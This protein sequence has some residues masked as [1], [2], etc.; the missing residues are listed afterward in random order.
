MD[1]LISPKADALLNA[2]I[3]YVLQQLQPANLQTTLIT[4]ID[5][6]LANAP[7]ITLN[8]AVTPKMIKDTVHRYAVEL[9]LGGGVFDIIGDIARTVYNHEIHQKTTLNDLVSDRQL[10]D[11]L[12]KILEMKDFRER[13]IRELVANPMYSSLASDVLY[14]GIRGYIWQSAVGNGG[15]GTKSLI[16]FSQTMLSKA[17]VG[18]EEL[19]ESNLRRYIQKSISAVLMESE[20]FL[21]RIDVD[22]LRDT[23]LD[24]WHELKKHKASL[25]HQFLTSLDVEEFLVMF[26]EFWRE[27]RQTEYFNVLLNSGIDA[28]FNRYGD[29]TL[30]VLLE[31]VGIQREMLV[32]DA[33]RF[34]P[35]I[36]AMMKGKDLLVPMI[37]AH[38][39]DFYRSDAVA[40]IL[41][42][43]E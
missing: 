19:V 26:Y 34:A 25:A 22:K 32:A 5:L 27:F 31:E 36:L 14:H 30:D 21:L 7:L 29:T 28:F 6:I 18:F 23:L 11:I 3:Q 13:I 15:A 38:L 8:E 35:P 37:R 39:E 40:H 16:K 4:E 2:H 9:E 41:A 20:H 10:T 17:P 24:I 1:N 42:T 33:L 12:D 43:V